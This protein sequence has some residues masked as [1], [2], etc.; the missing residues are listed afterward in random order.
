VLRWL[1]TWAN[2]MELL[3]VG[4]EDSYLPQSAWRNSP[5]W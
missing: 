3:K 2:T 4:Q 1:R 5:R